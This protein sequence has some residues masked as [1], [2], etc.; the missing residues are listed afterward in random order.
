MNEKIKKLLTKEEIEK[1]GFVYEP[2]RTKCKSLKLKLPVPN[3]NLIND[4]YKAEIISQ[5]PFV[6]VHEVKKTENPYE[7]NPNFLADPRIL[8]VGHT[9]KESFV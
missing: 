1:S 3:D 9:R 5:I 8:V 7:G 4:E 6:Y 2:D